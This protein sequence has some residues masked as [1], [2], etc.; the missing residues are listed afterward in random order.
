MA[1]EIDSYIAG[2]HG[3]KFSEDDAVLMLTYSHGSWALDAETSGL[4]DGVSSEVY[5][6]HTLSYELHRANLL[7]LRDEDKPKILALLGTDL[8]ELLQRIANGHSIEFDGRNRVGVLTPDAQQASD[9]LLE[10]IDSAEYD[11]AFPSALDADEWLGESLHEIV[12]KTPEAILAESEEQ[13]VRIWGGACA[14]SAVL[15]EYAEST[16]PPTVGP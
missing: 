16:H 5:H 8:P 10:R 1:F 4:S 11:E 12:H 14:V 3:S 7:V 6:R 9:T 13:G 15:R 2:D